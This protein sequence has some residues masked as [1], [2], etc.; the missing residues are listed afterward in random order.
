MG[1][2]ACMGQVIQFPEG[3]RPASEKRRDGH[4]SATV[5]ILPVVRIERMADDP[6]T[7]LAPTAG[8]S[9]GRR[10]RRRAAR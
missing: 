1:V 3:A 6:D 8:N 2:G 9:S 10:R 7:G 5:V 4:A